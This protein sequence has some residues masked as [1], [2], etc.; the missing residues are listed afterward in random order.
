VVVSL[1]SSAVG[2]QRVKILTATVGAAAFVTMVAINAAPNV[3][4][5]GTDQN[6]VAGSGAGSSDGVFKQPNIP[7]MNMGATATWTAPDSVLATAKAV[8]AK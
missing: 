1:G 7:G 2:T 6:I 3:V 5:D 4:G 8:P